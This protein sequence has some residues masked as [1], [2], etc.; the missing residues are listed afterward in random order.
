[1]SD[2]TIQVEGE[3]LEAALQA[4]ATQLEVGRDAVAYKYDREHLASGASTVRIFA[5]KKSAEV[6]ER[7]AKA[8]AAEPP[9][10]EARR[11]DRPRRDDRGGRRDDRGP[12]R[13]RGRDDRGGRRDDRGDRGRSER[14]DQGP[15]RRN[16]PEDDERL[17]EAARVLVKQVLAGEGPRTMESL[18][19]YERHLVH[20]IA[21]DAGGL[22]T[23]SSGEGLRKTVHIELDG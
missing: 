14:R 9:P 16:T 2:E 17:R 21:A 23:Y 7:E 20:T 6:M 15:P 1:M 13:G 18:N 5:S 10:S 3:T 19:S 4:A 8:R 22:K 12:P 11:D